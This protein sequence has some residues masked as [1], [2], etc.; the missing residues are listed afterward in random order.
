[1]SFL[2]NLIK[3]AAPIVAAVSPEPI[4]K[5]AATAITIGQQQQEYKY[6][7]N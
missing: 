7:K 6:Q 5:A 1:M 4:S 3:K 2:S